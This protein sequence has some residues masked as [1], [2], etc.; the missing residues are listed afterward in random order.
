MSLRRL[1]RKKWRIK[2]LNHQDRPV[3][4]KYFLQGVLREWRGFKNKTQRIFCRAVS[5]FI[6]R[7]KR[8]LSLAEASFGILRTRQRSQ[9]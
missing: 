7:D 6:A 4:Q 3:R 2:I 5:D 8:F 1:A 9:R